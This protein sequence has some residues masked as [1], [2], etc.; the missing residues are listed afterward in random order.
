MS[1]VDLDRLAAA[2]AYR[3]PSDS[4][5]E[6]AERAGQLLAA[7]TRVLDVGGGPGNHSAV[8]QQQGHQ[9]VLLDPSMTML[10]GATGRGLTGVRA[11]AQAMPFQPGSFALVWFHLSIH[12]GDWKRS[13]DEALRVVDN[14]GRIEIWTLGADHYEHSFLTSWFP[15]IAVIDAGRFP[16]PGLLTGYLGDRVK[17]ISV[18]R[19]I[20]TVIKTAGAWIP[21]IEAGFVSTLQLLS[22]EERE[23]GIQAI[24]RRYP[25]SAEQIAYELRFTR[26]VADGVRS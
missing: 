10:I 19:S 15:S 18:A 7:G 16:D 6:R 20:E 13:I 22:R 5:I 1:D 25:D 14:G 21:A 24:R 8:W 23:R 26:I 4:S 2:Y 17:S 9:P 11:T 3:P 12:Y